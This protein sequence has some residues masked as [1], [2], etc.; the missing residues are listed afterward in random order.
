L[1]QRA[2][3]KSVSVKSFLLDQRAI[4]GVGNIYASEALWLAR[5][6]PTLPAG[7][8]GVEGA[9][10]LSLAVQ[11]VL[12]FAIENGGT[13]LRDFVGA[14]GEPGTNGEQLLVY[15]RSGQP[16]HRCQRSIKKVVLQGRATYFCPA[17]QRP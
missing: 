14:D 9:R 2:A 10:A 13:S 15:G 8:L 6:A 4:A 17:C 11:E 7:R 16:C 1:W 5:I 12:L 3:G